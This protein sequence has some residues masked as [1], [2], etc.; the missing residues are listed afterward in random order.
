MKY[1]KSPLKSI[2]GY[3]ADIRRKVDEMHALADRKFT[4]DGHLLGSIGEGVASLLF[5][6]DLIPSQ[7][8]AGF[9][10]YLPNGDK[11][12]IKI[13]S[14][15]TGDVSLNLTKELKDIIESEGLTLITLIV[16]ENKLLEPPVCC[17]IT[18]ESPLYGMIKDGK[19]ISFT[20]LKENRIDLPYDKQ[21]FEEVNSW[22][23]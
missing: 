10:G 8:N 11:A 17:K 14:I 7:S 13:R 18:T 12:E 15:T 21:L 4:I 20:K 9:D 2:I 16:G 23:A 3:Y 1:D 22:L 5:G 6:I 19:R